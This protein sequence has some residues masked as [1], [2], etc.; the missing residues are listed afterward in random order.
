MKRALLFLALLISCLV[1]PPSL[2]ARILDTTVCDIL[3]NPQT[4]PATQHPVR[5]TS[6]D[7]TLQPAG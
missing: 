2:P 3:A 4:V 6:I 5:V 7:Y 1:I